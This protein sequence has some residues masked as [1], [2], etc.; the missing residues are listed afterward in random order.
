M[1]SH[2]YVKTGFKT[3]IY[4]I[5]TFYFSK[6]YNIILNLPSRNLFSTKLNL[7]TKIFKLKCRIIQKNFILF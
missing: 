3:K 7:V 2:S 4:S 5:C 1:K 6:C